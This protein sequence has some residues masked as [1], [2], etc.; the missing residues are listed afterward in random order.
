MEQTNYNDVH[1]VETIVN[2]PFSWE[3]KPGLSKV[4][5]HGHHKY[6]CF[7]SFYKCRRGSPEYEEP[8]DLRSNPF[9][10]EGDDAI[11]S[12]KGIG[13]WIEWPLNN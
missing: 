5:T 9:Q 10:G 12:P 7:Y 3:H 4:T 11:L 1:C 8:R 2:V 13:Y 6:I